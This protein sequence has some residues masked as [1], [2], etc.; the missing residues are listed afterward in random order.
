MEVVNSEKNFI[1]SIVKYLQFFI[2]QGN[3][4]CHCWDLQLPDPRPLEGDCLHQ[5]SLP[6]ITDDHHESFMINV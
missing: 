2:S 5:V 1:N 3:L 6:G 4:R